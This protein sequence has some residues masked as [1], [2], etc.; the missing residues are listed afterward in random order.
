M[1][2]SLPGTCEI[3]KEK[4]INL[5]SEPG[6]AVHPDSWSQAVELVACGPCGHGTSSPQDSRRSAHIGPRDCQS[7]LFRL[8]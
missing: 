3:V 5:I 2:K 1:V 6:M 8:G 4:R 7:L